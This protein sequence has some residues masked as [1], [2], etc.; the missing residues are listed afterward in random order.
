MT[1]AMRVAW[2]A[3]LSIVLC[4]LAAETTPQQP[5]AHDP[6]AAAAPPLVIRRLHLVRPDLIHHPLLIEV[7]C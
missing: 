1:S 2:R 6:I 7:V 4:S 5:Q 3:I